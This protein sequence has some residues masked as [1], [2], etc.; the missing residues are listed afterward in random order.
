MPGAALQLFIPFTKVDEERREVAGRL[1]QEMV[2]R[3]RE[4][5]D[6]ETSRPYFEAWSD[7]FGKATDGKSLG[8]LR[9]MHRK[10]IA[11]GR[12][13]NITFDDET[14]AIDIVAHVDD[15]A[16]WAKC[17]AG[18]Y[19]G[20]SAGGSVVRK[21]SEPGSPGVK[22]FTANPTEASLADFP[23]VPTA[24]FTLVKVGGATEERH[25]AKIA[26]RT[27]VDPKEGK[28]TYGSVEFADPT[29]KKYPIDTEAHVRAAWAYINMPKNAAKY[30]SADVEAI[31]GRIEAAAKKHGITIA[32]VA[33]ADGAA[34]AKGLYDVGRLAELVQSL[35]YLRDC[36][37]N[38]AL[39]EQD[40]SG[41]PAMLN[42]HVQGLAECLRAM[43]DEETAELAQLTA[44]EGTIMEN[45]TTTGA[46]EP[47][48]KAHLEAHM[49]GL[50]KAHKS[51]VALHKAVGEHAE[52]LGSMV[53]S[54]DAEK[55]AGSAGSADDFQKVAD[56]VTALEAELKKTV[57]ERD[58]LA[59]TAKELAELGEQLVGTRR[60]ALRIVGKDAD[61]GGAGGESTKTASGDP[62]DQT[63]A[64]TTLSPEDR[65]KAAFKKAFQNP[66]VQE[67]D[68]G[69]AAKAAGAK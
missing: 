69:K 25:F 41:L 38:E 64:D 42:E 17:M 6:F 39:Y 37:A 12:L 58:E 49:K 57:G 15:D 67:L 1:T 20:F 55:I 21:W 14:K 53:E 63:I 60:A 45:K 33:T 56:R 46:G 28:D 3:D 68:F 26:A 13:T 5:M 8:N 16:E 34:F 54:S 24:T 62:L 40:G 27:D 10:D 4:I 65:A 2:D 66:H 44:L 7:W 23:A 30:S 35:V 29:N 9:V 52:H 19:T 11:A 47:F 61:D 48:T 51:A 18:T 50:A 31:K 32:K 36:S 22:R 59:K 43:V